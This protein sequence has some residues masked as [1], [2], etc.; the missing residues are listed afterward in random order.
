MHVL[1][2]KTEVELPG[3]DVHRMIA[4]FVTDGQSELYQLE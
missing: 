1:D 2:T 4:I 3:A